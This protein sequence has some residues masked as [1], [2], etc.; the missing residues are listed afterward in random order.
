M[1]LLLLVASGI[2]IA[3]ALGSLFGAPA[4]FG[5]GIAIGVVA[6]V[7]AVKEQK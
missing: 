3:F 7:M 1:K 5:I 2:A 4:D 6:F